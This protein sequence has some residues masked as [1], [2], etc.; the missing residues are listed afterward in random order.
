MHRNA[1]LTV[2]GRKL[3]VDRILNGGWPAATAA[4]AQGCS[5]ATAYKWVSR[6]ESEGLAGLED[7]S[8]RPHTSPRRLSAGREQQIIDRRQAALEGPHPIGW[9]L[10][11]APSTVH[12][13]IR[14]NKLPRL[15]DID[16]ATKTVVRYQC[17]RPGELIHIDIKKQARIPDGGGW[18]IHGDEVGRR[19]GQA[20]QRRI[21]GKKVRCLGYDYL[22]IAVDDC[23]RIA[24]AEA[25]PDERKE[26]ATE[27]TKRAID[28]FAT[29]GITVER[30]MTDGGSCYRSRQF[31]D[32]LVAYGVKHKRTRPYRPQTN[33]KVER[34]NLT[35]K[36]GW[37]YARAYATNQARLDDLPG[38][39][40]Y[41][42]HHRPHMA[43][44][45]K[46]PMASINNLC[47]NHN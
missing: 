29:L 41:Y 26:T 40:H 10:G 25:H 9:A 22:H 13:V 31:R 45:G 16:R 27:F 35:L 11:I 8:S 33:G 46:A 34:F 19:N 7:R 12:K 38:W 17:E 5:S 21:N 4:E 39:L 32:L 30:V 20:H 18:K 36:L 3:L 47:G 1:K 37:A 43:H 28:R 44:R 6:F 2:E 23:S 24:Y 42:N 14:R 15:S